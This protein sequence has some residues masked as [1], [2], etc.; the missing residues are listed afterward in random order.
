MAKNG[1]FT[2]EQM[3]DAITKSKGVLSTAA[4][5]LK[6]SRQT[7]YNYAERHTTVKEAIREQQEVTGDYVEGQLMKLIDELNP[8]AIIFYCKTRLKQRGYIE[9]QEQ[10]IEQDGKVTL[11][12]VYDRTDSPSEEPSPKAK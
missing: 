11:K 4:A 1:K 5:Y 7:I 9:R 3:I 2:A 8:A 10:R 6:C 12:V